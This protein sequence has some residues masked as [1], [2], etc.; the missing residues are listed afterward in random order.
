MCAASSRR[1][2]RDRGACQEARSTSSGTGLSVIAK[3]C[4]SATSSTCY[5]QMLLCSSVPPLYIFRRYVK[6]VS[7]LHHLFAMFI[8]RI[9]FVRRFS[10]CSLYCRSLSQIFATMFTNSCG[11]QMHQHQMCYMQSPIEPWRRSFAYSTFSQPPRICSCCLIR[12]TI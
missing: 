8:C 5:G 6:S 12:N 2:G 3:S 7:Q 9:P 1:L 11:P 4:F 10:Y